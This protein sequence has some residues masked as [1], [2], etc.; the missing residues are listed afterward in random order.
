MSAKATWAWSSAA[1]GGECD[2]RRPAPDHLTVIWAQ[3]VRVRVGFPSGGPCGEQA[4][5]FFGG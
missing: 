3:I 4:Q 5:S 2:G 1:P